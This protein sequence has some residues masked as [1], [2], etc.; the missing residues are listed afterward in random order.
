MESSIHVIP[1]IE[2]LTPAAIAQIHASSLRILSEIGIRV[3]LA[4]SDKGF[5]IRTWG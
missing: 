3:D 4:N 1:H 5:Q 2:V